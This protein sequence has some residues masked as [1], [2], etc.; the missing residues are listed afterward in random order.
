MGNTLKQ[1]HKCLRT[2]RSP[3][4]NVAEEMNG[5]SKHAFDDNIIV[6]MTIWTLIV[7]ANILAD[8]FVVFLIFTLEC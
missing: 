7:A 1:K 5:D 2:K 8:R 4:A 6:G 3:C